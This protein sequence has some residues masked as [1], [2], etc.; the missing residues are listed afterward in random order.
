M[1]K[2][3]TKFGLKSIVAA[4]SA[5]LGLV[6]ILLMFAPA[7]TVKNADT[8]FTGAQMTF[9]YSK[10]ASSVLGSATA[11][12][13]TFSF[14]NLL[15][16]LFALAGIVFCVL[17]ALGKLGKLAPVLAAACFLAA[18]VMFFIVIPCCVP[19]E[20]FDTLL[21]IGDIFGGGKGNGKDSLVLGAGAIVA[22]ILSLLAAIGSFC[23]GFV[24]KK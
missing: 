17:A 3:K 5:L 1:A 15:P 12:Y 9:G 20:E 2:K 11:V 6:A 8:A 14:A 24:I 18:G 21:G 7:A 19:S 23:A 22:G 4:V 13:F 10:T 16:Y